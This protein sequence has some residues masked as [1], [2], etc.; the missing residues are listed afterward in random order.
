VVDLTYELT[1]PA[2]AKVDPA[3]IKGISDWAKASGLTK[4]QA[5]ALLARD[6]KLAQDYSA[7]DQKAIADQLA[8]WKSEMEKDPEFGGLRLQETIAAS[9]K[10]LTHFAG[11]EAD[12]VHKFMTETG[13]NNHPMV[14]RLLARIGKSLSEDR[15]GSSGI[16]TQSTPSASMALFGNAVKAAQ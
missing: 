4:V 5:E 14:V 16:P 12:A 11:K 8:G 6:L 7:A 15:Q 9:N 10:A 13:A 2:D 1:A 3:D